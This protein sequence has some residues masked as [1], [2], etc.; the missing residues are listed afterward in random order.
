MTD[1]NEN[2]ALLC[3]MVDAVIALQVQ[4]I[5]ED[6]FQKLVFFFF[7]LKLIQIFLFRVKLYGHGFRYMEFFPLWKIWA[8]IIPAEFWP[9]W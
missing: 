4:V 8:K 2:Y 7:N 3:A 1:F 9:E 5:I 6:V